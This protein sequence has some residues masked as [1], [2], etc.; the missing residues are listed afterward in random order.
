MKRTPYILIL[1]LLFAFNNG[2]WAQ[3]DCLTATQL[4]CWHAA[5][6]YPSSA[7]G[8][9]LTGGWTANTAPTCFGV[10]DGLG[11]GY[12][13]K[14]EG[15]GDPI[16]VFLCGSDYD[17][18]L[19]I[20]D[21]TC[22]ALNCVAAGDDDCGLI[23]LQSEVTMFTTLGTMY[24]VLV[25]G[26]PG[27]A[28]GNFSLKI[29]CLPP[30]PVTTFCFTQQSVTFSTDPYAGTSVI[31]S[32]D[33]HSG[34]ISMGFDFCFNG[35]TYTNAYI[36]SNGY[37]TFF[38]SPGNPFYSPWRT[39]AI[40]SAAPAQIANSIL[41]PWQDLNPS[42]GGT[43]MYQTLGTAPDRRFVVTYEN[44]PYYSC[45]SSLYTGQITLHETTNCITTMIANKPVCSGWNSGNAV[46]GVHNN[47]GTQAVTIASQNNTQFTVT[48]LGNMFVPSCAPCSTLTTASCLN[49]VLP[50]DL[51][52]FRGSSE[53]DENILE[54]ATAS[55]LNS[56][57]FVVE[58]SSNGV[59]FTPISTLDAAGSSYQTIEYA[60]NDIPP[61]IGLNYYRVIS[62][63]LDGAFTTSETVALETK[64]GGQPIIYPNPATDE[65]YIRL[66]S[67]VDLPTSVLI[68]DIYGRAIREITID[69][70]EIPISLDNLASG[71]YF[72]EIPALS[73][74]STAR[75]I[76]E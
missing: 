1:T 62:V 68:R 76:V 39:A 20:Y 5:A 72:V 31:L 22:G 16:R 3:D 67:N 12:W 24:Y 17:T 28:E 42:N 70:L 32:D 47:N 33:R 58:R 54:W 6:I 36:S 71:S 15:N 14:F 40:P 55:E 43:I 50:I 18:R 27:T 59:E 37:I 25:H 64:L 29:T 74:G 35:T 48:S 51:L 23:G 75:L 41:G 4:E 2:T 7:S 52:Y 56:H 9:T 60:I 30:I 19:R 53:G 57:H 13:A 73:S 66:P 38:V 61:I 34:A 69:A 26:G 11:A 45:T 49:V 46:H 63:D 21:G 65:I 44:V 10:A 8:S